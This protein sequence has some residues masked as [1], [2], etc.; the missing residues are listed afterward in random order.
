MMP[1]TK[2]KFHF[3]GPTKMV[4]KVVMSATLKSSDSTGRDEWY[5]PQDGTKTVPKKH[6]Q[7]TFG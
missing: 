7:Y 4:V 2:D 1:Q 3:S 5:H 6:L